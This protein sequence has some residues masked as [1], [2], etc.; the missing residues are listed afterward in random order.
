MNIL[1]VDDNNSNRMIMKYLL[2]DY[3]E[4]NSGII[5]NTQEARDG[6]EALQMCKENSYDIVFMDIMMPNMDG[7]EATKRIRGIDTKTMIIAVSAMDDNESKKLILNNGAEDYISK[8]INADVFVSRMDNY[9]TLVESR[10]SKKSNV[11]KVNLFSDEIYKRHTKFIINSE[12]SLS[13]FWEF[14]LLNVRDKSDNLSD[15]VRTIV[16]IADFQVRHSTHSGIYIEESD[17][18]QYFTLT[19]I[20]EI[21]LKKIE[22]IIKKNHPACR[23]RIEDE[24]I[25]F[26]LKK[27]AI[28]ND[29]DLLSAEIKNVPLVI[30]KE[31]KIIPIEEIASPLVLKKSENLQIFNYME[32][33]DLYDLEEY[34]GKLNSLLLVVGNGDVSEEEIADIYTYLDKI[35]GILASYNEVYMISKALT[36]LSHDMSTHISEFMKNSEALGPMC[37]AFSKDISN[38]IEMSF[39]TGAPSVQF[40]NDTIVVNCQTIGGILKM[41]EAADDGA[42]DFDDIFDF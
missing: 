41:D 15:I 7:I 13:E 20:G 25:S 17:E 28:K 33:E 29:T 38:W 3:A 4:N 23:Y 40:M 37:R 18:A 32:E 12:D 35:A 21:P 36:E 6:L 2:D 19:D 26:E 1:I 8:P 34:A 27:S 5:F 24:K 22:H 39:H 30:Q 42:E 10:I 16:S 31:E 9:I 11:E 14:F